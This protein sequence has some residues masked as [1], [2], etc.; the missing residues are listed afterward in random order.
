MTVSVE[1]GYAIESIAITFSG[2]T[3][4]GAYEASVGT[5]TDGVV[6]EWNGFSY[7]VTFTATATSRMQ[8]IE[9]VYVKDEA[10]TGIAETVAIGASGEDIIYNLNGQR[11]GKVQKGLNIV[12]GKKVIFK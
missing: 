8:K 9:V 12:N 7:S 3:Y 1:E 10:G 4:T 6:A 2:E 5:Y 11:L